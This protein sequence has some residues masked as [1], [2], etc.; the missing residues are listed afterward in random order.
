MIEMERCDSMV[1]SQ[2]AASPHARFSLAKNA[3]AN[4]Q[5]TID[6]LSSPKAI[7]FVFC[8]SLIQDA[9]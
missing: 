3:I 1:W 2:V 7:R 6:A 8:Q 4:T 5:C 9:L